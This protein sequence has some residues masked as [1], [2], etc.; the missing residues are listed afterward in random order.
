LKYIHYPFLCY[1]TGEED[2]VMKSGN[3]LFGLLYILILISVTQ[4]YAN[5]LTFNPIVNENQNRNIVQAIQNA[6]I[7][8]GYDPGLPDG[9][10]GP[11]TSAALKAFQR[12]HKLKINGRPNRSNLKAIENSLVSDN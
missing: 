1:E 7:E 6:L 11:R 3:R 4:V 12:D 2:S 5:Q 8:A 9:F 10:D